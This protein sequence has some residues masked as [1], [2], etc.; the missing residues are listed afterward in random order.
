[1]EILSFTFGVLLMIG[2]LL[3]ITIVAG[4]V[5]VLKQQ[6]AIRQ[7]QDQLLDLERNVYEQIVEESQVI[8]NR[9]DFIESHFPRAINDQITDAVT[10]CN[11]YTDKRVDK[12]IDKCSPT[13]VTK[14]SKK[15]INENKQK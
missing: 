1:M 2:L 13:K 7:L 14:Q 4:T 6:K 12:L 15:L 3:V 5:K 8:T 11:S 10:Q 9:I